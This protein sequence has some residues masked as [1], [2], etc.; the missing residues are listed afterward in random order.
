MKR[1]AIRKTRRAGLSLIEVMIAIVVLAVLVVGSSSF[2]YHTR[3]TLAHEGR[4]RI[5]ME[6][7]NARLEEIRALP[8]ATITNLVPRTGIH[9]L[10][11]NAAGGWALD[12]TAPENVTRNGVTY[13]LNTQI[14]HVDGYLMDM[15]TTVIYAVRPDGAGKD[16]VTLRTYYLPPG[17]DYF[18]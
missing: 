5:A 17:I 16:F 18:P 6:I 7:A 8:T 3:A 15:E 13:K 9:H 11:R 1:P 10:T 12:A 2:M 4:K 14:S